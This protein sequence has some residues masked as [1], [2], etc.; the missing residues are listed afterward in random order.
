M[1][2]HILL[3]MLLH[4]RLRY[5]WQ[6]WKKTLKKLNLKRVLNPWPLR[7][8]CRC[9]KNWFIKQSGGLSL[10]TLVINLQKGDKGGGCEETIVINGRQTC[11]LFFWQVKYMQYCTGIFETIAENTLHAQF[12]TSNMQGHLLKVMT[13]PLIVIFFALVRNTSYN[14]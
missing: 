10:C 6:E 14:K 12:I 1:G 4:A 7:Y 8:R 3:P 13:C 11:A 5:E 9:S 2:Y